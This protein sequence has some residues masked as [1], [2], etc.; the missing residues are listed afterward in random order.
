MK[1][2]I[3]SEG[4]PWLLNSYILSDTTLIIQHILQLFLLLI[5]QMYTM[6]SHK[7]NDL[8][9]I[10]DYYPC[11]VCYSL[12]QGLGN[13]AQENTMFWLDVLWTWPGARTY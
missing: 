6:L 9:T 13:N 11:R 7:N 8:V 4:Y 12:P 2:N 5:V 10:L 3:S 1:C